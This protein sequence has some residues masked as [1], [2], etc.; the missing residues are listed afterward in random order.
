MAV[1]R[2]T[3]R[4]APRSVL[5]RPALCDV[6]LRG[7]DVLD[8]RDRDHHG[9]SPPLDFPSSCPTEGIEGGESGNILVRISG[10]GRRRPV[11]GRG[12]DLPGV[13]ER[14]LDPAQ[15]PPVLLLDRAALRGAELPRPPH[16]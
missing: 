12:T 11:A 2:P 13:P 7:L 16:A 1:G 8:L 3:L 9:K 15:E 5:R 14:V 6:L 10:S 4:A